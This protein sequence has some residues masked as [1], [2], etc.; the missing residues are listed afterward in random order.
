MGRK[1]KGKS[2]QQTSTKNNTPVNPTTVKLRLA[3]IVN[4][5]DA[6]N[7]PLPRDE[8]INVIE[9]LARYAS[10]VSQRG[11]EF[12]LRCLIVWVTNDDDITD[13]PK[14]EST[15]LFGGDIGYLLKKETF[16]CQCLRPHWWNNNDTPFP[17]VD[18]VREKYYPAPPHDNVPFEENDW[19]NSNLIGY[20][21][22]QHQT[23]LLNLYTYDFYTYVKNHIKAWLRRYRGVAKAD[24]VTKIWHKMIGKDVT[25]EESE[26]PAA[27][28]AYI[29]T[30]RRMLK[31]PTI[32]EVE[33][34]TKIFPRDFIDTKSPNEDD[35][36][37]WVKKNLSTTV[38]YFH[39]LSHYLEGHPFGSMEHSKVYWLHESKSKRI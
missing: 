11:G 7:N 13:M 9:Q 10:Q 27:I 17:L 28:K 16:F 12:V 32:E 30:H 5:V 8:F 36:S 4:K 3:N 39:F 2:Q 14:S 22:R 1:N 35:N 29:N 38:R 18:Y 6:D 26:D 34:G 31:L 24:L 25:F 37:K 21:A 33:N 19:V 20:L 15:R 23:N